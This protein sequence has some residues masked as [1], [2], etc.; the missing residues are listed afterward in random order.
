VN[1]HPIFLAATGD[2][3]ALRDVAGIA[4]ASRTGILASVPLAYM[5]AITFTRLAATHGDPQPVAAQAQPM[6]RPA[7]Q[8]AASR[9]PPVNPALPG[10]PADGGEAPPITV[11]GEPES[12][13][14]AAFLRM[15]QA[16]PKA[17]FAID[18]GMR[19]R[20]ADRLK[21]TRD[22]YGYAVSRL[23]GVRDEQGYDEALSDIQA[24]L[25]PLGVTSGFRT[26]EY[27][28]DM[29]RRGYH[30]ADNSG[31]LDGSSLDLLPPPGKSMGWLKG[32]VKRVYP[33]ARLLDE[34][35]H[36]HATFPGWY[37]APAIGGAKDAGL[38]N[39]MAGQ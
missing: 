38:S 13:A 25:A 1:P 19:D 27:Q 18:T 12:E 14:D 17:A 22:A 24:L 15:L 34:G 28:A 2:V 9:M 23:G 3:Q 7:G 37:S 16:D 11:L 6:Q 39:P 8:N 29:K 33:D 4:Y 31:H 35:N 32:Q 36:L 20:A 21:M 10:D 30:P 26:P 5:E